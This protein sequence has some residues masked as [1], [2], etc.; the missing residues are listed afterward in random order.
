MANT[1]SGSSGSPIFLEYTINVI[2]IHKEGNKFNNENYADFI[3]PVINIIK[4]DINKKRNN[5][6]YVN[7][8]Y[9][10]DDGKYYEGQFKNNLPNG[11]GI[12]YYSN[13]NILFEGDFI[14]GKFEGK[15]KY[16]YGDG[17]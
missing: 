12:K 7:G 13:G 14:N 8:R 10:W 15:G 11:K 3:Y 9:I 6:R 17:N 4:E 2:G 16:I 5:G 1:E